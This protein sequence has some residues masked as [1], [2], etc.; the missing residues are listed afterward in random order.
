MYSY[1]IRCCCI[2]SWCLL[3]RGAWSRCLRAVLIGH[4]APGVLINEALELFTAGLRRCNEPILWFR[5]ALA[6]VKFTTLCRLHI[7]LD[8]RHLLILCPS[9]CI[10]IFMLAV[11]D[12]L[13]SLAFQNLLDST[14]MGLVR[15]IRFLHLLKVLKC[16]GISFDLSFAL[17]QLQKVI[18]V[19]VPTDV[20]PEQQ[21]FVKGSLDLKSAIGIDK[22]LVVLAPDNVVAL[23]ERLRR[24]HENRAQL[25]VAVL[26]GAW[27]LAK[28]H[29][30]EVTGPK[31]CLWLL[32]LVLVPLPKHSQQRCT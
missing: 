24:I 16:F 23:L 1:S 8:V 17:A 9:M 22:M 32:I 10:T 18:R 31:E 2:S 7:L 26:C 5:L 11:L 21:A 30:L 19:L 3:L 14:W 29:L 15:M 28:L 4:L 27:S 12:L 6:I 13:F 20:V 25:I